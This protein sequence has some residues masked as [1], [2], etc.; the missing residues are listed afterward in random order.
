MRETY[1]GFDYEDTVSGKSLTGMRQHY[2]LDT[3]LRWLYIPH[4]SI[5]WD[6]QDNH[7]ITAKK[8]VDEWKCVGRTDL[9]MIFN[10]LKENVGV[11]KVVE[12][13]VEDFEA[14]DR[15]PHSDQIIEACLRDLKIEIWN[16]KRMDISSE[17]IYKVASE[18]VK[19]VYL[20]CSGINA[21]LRSW[22]D[23]N[24]L[25]RLKHV[26]LILWGFECTILLIR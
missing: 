22:S 9:F 20:Y 8:K 14:K 25:A 12:V 7:S 19:V 18:H 24:G 15:R 3:M 21:V 13:V 10:W 5:K 23:R 16:W 17:L 26:S 4:I 2:K 6:N 1:L 11:R